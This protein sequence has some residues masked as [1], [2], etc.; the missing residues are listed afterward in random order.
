M[1]K[2]TKNRVRKS[3]ERRLTI[4]NSGAEPKR[5]PDFERDRA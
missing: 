1:G 3:S 5:L 4:S 2:K